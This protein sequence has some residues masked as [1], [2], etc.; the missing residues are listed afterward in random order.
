MVRL[1]KRSSEGRLYTYSCEH[2]HDLHARTKQGIKAEVMVSNTDID[3]KLDIWLR[4]GH[5]SEL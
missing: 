3:E 2:K 1:S 4:V 5:V